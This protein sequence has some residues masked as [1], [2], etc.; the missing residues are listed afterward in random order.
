MYDPSLEN[1][2]V[3]IVVPASSVCRTA[4]VAAS[5]S[6][7][8]LSYETDASCLPSG[9]KATAHTEAEWSSSVCNKLL[10]S[11]WTPYDLF[12]HRGTR[13]LNCFLI[14]LLA[15]AKMSA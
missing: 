13:S 10:Q 1:E 6:L 5:H 7:T 3:R 15:G 2:S 12:I 14:V 11:S 8:V 9:E 4:P